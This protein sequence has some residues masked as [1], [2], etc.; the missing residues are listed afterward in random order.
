MLLKDYAGAGG[1]R[2]IDF[3]CLISP[4]QVVTRGRDS[5]HVPAPLSFNQAS[6]RTQRFDGR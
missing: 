4:I 6:G 1:G 2:L 5:E 3:I